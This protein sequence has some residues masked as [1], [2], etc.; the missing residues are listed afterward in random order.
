[1]SDL[2]ASGV[3]FLAAARHDHAAR[4]VTYRR[5]AASVT[6]L[7]TKGRSQTATIDGARILYDTTAVDWI[8]RPT[9]LILNA[10]PVEPAIGDEILETVGDTVYV[11]AV[12]PTETEPPA[13]P[14]HDG[15]GLRIHTKLIG[16]EPG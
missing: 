10:A 2:L 8:V 14:I 9:D 1:M 16:T 15:A 3:A 11:Y 6:L 7:A 13:V 5:D 4:P 12:Q